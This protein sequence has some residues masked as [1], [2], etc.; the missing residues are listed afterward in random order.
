VWDSRKPETAL[1]NFK[2]PLC[3]G[4][5][6][7]AFSPS[8]KRLVGVDINE[9]TKADGGFAIFDVTGKGGLLAKAKKGSDK[10]IELFWSDESVRNHLHYYTFFIL[11]VIYYK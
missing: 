7:L 1:M 6:S 4:V 3:K 5:A 10:I 11:L 8:G 2:A 9:D